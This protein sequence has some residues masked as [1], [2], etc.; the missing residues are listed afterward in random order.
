MPRLPKFKSS[1][2]SGAQL[3]ATCLPK[4]LARCHILRATRRHVPSPAP[5]TPRY[6]ISRDPPTLLLFFI[7]TLLEPRDQEGVR[8]REPSCMSKSGEEALLVSFGGL[9]GV[10]SALLSFH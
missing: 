8:L 6:K 5:R 2:H 9:T 4:A 1:R 7:F 10:I 3:P